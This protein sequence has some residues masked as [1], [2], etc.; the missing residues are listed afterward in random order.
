[1]TRAMIKKSPRI[2][3]LVLNIIREFVANI[4]KRLKRLRI[5][6][7]QQLRILIVP[8]HESFHRCVRCQT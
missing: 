4:L 7:P 6:E 2:H 5:L 8:S 3:E 1:M